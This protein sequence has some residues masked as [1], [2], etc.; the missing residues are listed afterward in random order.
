MIRILGSAVATLFA[1][2]C[3]WSI[4]GYYLQCAGLMVTGAIFCALG[5]MGNDHE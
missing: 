3:F 4:D 1:V 2:F 5:F